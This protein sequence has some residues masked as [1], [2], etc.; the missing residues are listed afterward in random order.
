MN[1]ASRLQ[2]LQPST[3]HLRSS[4]DMTDLKLRAVITTG[5]VN[6]T[7]CAISPLFTS[8]Y[9]APTNVKVKYKSQTT[10]Y[11]FSP[12]LYY[13]NTILSNYSRQVIIPNTCLR[14]FYVYSLKE[15][16]RKIQWTERTI[17]NADTKINKWQKSK[18]NIKIKWLNSIINVMWNKHDSV[19]VT[20]HIIFKGETFHEMTVYKRLASGLL[21]N[22]WLQNVWCQWCR[23]IKPSALYFMSICTNYQRS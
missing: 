10:H 15:P 3:E 20:H 21:K 12:A 6:L 18:E 14:A 5:V 22:I 4:D 9:T 8:L 1:A 23:G 19:T 11:Y 2:C 17:R 13:H 7:P 16:S